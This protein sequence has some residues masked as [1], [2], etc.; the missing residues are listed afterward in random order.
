[1]VWNQCDFQN[2][3]KEKSEKW[4]LAPQ[5]K[6]MMFTNDIYDASM[7]LMTLM[8]LVCDQYKK[9]IICITIL[10]LCFTCDR[11]K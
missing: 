2:L 10:Y 5:H 11:C 9:K 1:M 6:Q 7:C 4:K 3:E 8:A